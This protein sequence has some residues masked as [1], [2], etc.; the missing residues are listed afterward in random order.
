[1]KINEIFGFGKGNIDLDTISEYT[2]IKDELFRQLLATLI[3]KTTKKDDFNRH[4][5][6][7]GWVDDVGIEAD[8]FIYKFIIDKF[9]KK[10]GQDKAAELQD[11][12]KKFYKIVQKAFDK[13]IVR[14]LNFAKDT[15]TLVSSIESAFGKSPQLS[16]VLKQS[17]IAK[18]LFT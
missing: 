8:E 16:D 18:G 5:I 14:S 3:V 12:H 13:K 6:S 17:I 9:I 15:A 11:Q 4:I 1:M 10:Y 7:P 2:S